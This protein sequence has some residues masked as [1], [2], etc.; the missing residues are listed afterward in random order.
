MAIGPFVIALPRLFL[1]LGLAAAGLTAYLMGRRAGG[2]PEKPLWW[3]LLVGLVA[4]RLGFVLTHLGDYRAQPWE[5]LYFWQDGYLPLLGAMAAIL[6]AGLFALRGHYP[7]Q[8]LFPPLLMGLF[9]WG[10]LSYL[11]DALTQATEKPLPDLVLEDLAGRPV[12][13]A[14]FQGKP[15]VVNL[16]A[17][18]CPPCRREMPVLSAAQ[19][20]EPGVEFLFVNQAEGP[21][22]IRQY[23]SAERLRL[24]NILLDLG[25][26]LPRDF[27]APGLPTTLFFNADGRLVDTHLGELSRAGL[28]DYLRKLKE[29]E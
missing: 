9:V 20:A 23:L 18:W 4:A 19:R 21:A 17:S 15:V 8:R 13:L 5:A 28:G 1:L 6:A 14:D 10:G 12:N 11:N 24:E 29:T 16:W 3:T 27:N 7:P 25:G 22:T 26:R 2:S